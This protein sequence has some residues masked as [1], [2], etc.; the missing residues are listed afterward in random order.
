MTETM[1]DIAE[2]EYSRVARPS[3]RI[4]HLNSTDACVDKSMMLHGSLEVIRLDYA[5]SF[6][7]ISY[8]CGDPER[9][10]RILIDRKIV[11]I[12]K[13]CYNGLRC[14][15]DKLNVNHLWVDSISINAEDED[16]KSDQVHFMTN[17]RYCS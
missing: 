17:L 7:A 5:K 11:K 2:Y 6:D 13:N 12:T 9:S 1:D 4:L 3:I 10:D 16:E 14:L 8:A 15:R